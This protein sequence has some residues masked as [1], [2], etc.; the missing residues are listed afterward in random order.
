MSGSLG[1]DRIGGG[2]VQ[3]FELSDYLKNSC[4]VVSQSQSICAENNLFP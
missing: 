4:L 2:V 1:H 3:F